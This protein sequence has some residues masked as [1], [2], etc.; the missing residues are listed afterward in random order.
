MAERRSLDAER[1]GGEPLGESVA[2]RSAHAGRRVVHAV[3]EHALVAQGE[4]HVQLAVARVQV[5]LTE[6]YAC[7]ALLAEYL[8]RSRITTRI[9][10][11]ITN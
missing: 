3:V 4:G 11:R 8:Q 2:Q 5:G 9:I 1:H 10:K 7:L 6:G